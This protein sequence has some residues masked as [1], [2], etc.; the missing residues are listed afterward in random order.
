MTADDVSKEIKAKSLELKNFFKDVKA[1]LEEWKFSVE[2]TK[3]G[4]RIEV[5]AI[6]LIRHNKREDR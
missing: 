6:A 1:V 4:T 2:E 5:H 3:E